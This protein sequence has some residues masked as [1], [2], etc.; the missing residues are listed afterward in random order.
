MTERHTSDTGQADPPG[1][2]TEEPS[3]GGRLIASLREAVAFE[4]GERPAR[5]RAYR[6]AGD[7]WVLIR[8]ERTTG[9][10]LREAEAWREQGE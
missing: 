5:V 9:P 7:E 6:R 8:D 1:G 2:G 10:A 3:F 4:R